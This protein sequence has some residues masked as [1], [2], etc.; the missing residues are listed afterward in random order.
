MLVGAARGLDQELGY[1][2]AHSSYKGLSW[3]RDLAAKWLALL[4]H[5]VPDV[6]L[7]YL[8]APCTS[9][10]A[11][12]YVHQ[13]MPLDGLYAAMLVLFFEPMPAVRKGIDSLSIV[14]FTGQDDITLMALSLQCYWFAKFVQEVATAQM[15]LMNIWLEPAKADSN[16]PSRLTERNLDIFRDFHDMNY[17]VHW[18]D[19]LSA[20]LK[21]YYAGTTRAFKP[22]TLPSFKQFCELYTAR[23]TPELKDEAA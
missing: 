4:A 2:F 1:R 23:G 11:V 16:G 14:G 12:D 5:F 17:I 18:P 6:E 20:I 8:P 9:G 3:S 22:W 21:G 10:P 13:Y 19:P 15:A 7:E